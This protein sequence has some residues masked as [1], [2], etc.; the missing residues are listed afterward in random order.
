MRDLVVSRIIGSNLVRVGVISRAGS[1][2]T[3]AYDDEYLAWE[4]AIPLSLSLPLRRERFDV[5]AVRPYFD[6]LLPEGQ[7]R[8]ALAAKAGAREDDYLTLL[9][10]GGLDCIGDVVVRPADQAGTTWDEG[11][12]VPLERSELVDI[13]NGFDTLAERNMESRLSLA[14]TQGKVGLAHIPDAPIDE[15]WLQPVGGAGSTH[16]L[17]VTSNSRV[18][19]LEAICMRA[20]PACGLRAAGTDAMYVGQPVVVSERYDRLVTV[21][22]SSLQ[23]TRLHQEDI[24][25]AYGYS[26]AGK[27]LEL[28]GGTYATLSRLFFERSVSA[29]DD[30]EQLARIAVYDYMVG[31]CDNHL[32]NLSIITRGHA[33]RLAPMHDVTSTTFFEHFDRHM[34][35]RLG[36][37]SCI[38][39]IQPSDFEALSKDLKMG[40]RRMRA[41]CAEMAEAIVPAIFDAGNYLDDTIEGLGF[42]AEDLAD[43]VQ[44]RRMVVQAVAAGR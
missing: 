6:G 18:A 11:S 42:T 20:A 3:F 41:I 7:A 28:V 2:P 13:F 19:E 15:G 4:D 14:G 12:Y 16:I 36:S 22:S 5:T 24:A 27:Y 32:K 37:T 23:V 40:I 10:L 29:M 8:V 35:R 31:N 25:Q 44:E 1:Q 17:K 30:I 21:R 39:D 9:E 38:D 43:E 33:L 26:A 34:C